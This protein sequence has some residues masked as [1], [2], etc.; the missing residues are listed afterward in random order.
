MKKFNILSLILMIAIIA[1]SCVSAKKYN[2]L[3]NQ[4]YACNNELNYVTSEKID[5]GNQN[6][7]LTSQIF[8]LQE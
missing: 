6:K 3:N 1:T 7:D 5:L 4:N 8:S 2:A